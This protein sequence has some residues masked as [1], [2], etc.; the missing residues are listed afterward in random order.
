MDGSMDGSGAHNYSSCVDSDSGLS[1]AEEGTGSEDGGVLALPSTR[2]GG[3]FAKARRGAALPQHK[4]QQRLRELKGLFERALAAGGHADA[5][6]DKRFGGKQ[7]HP[8]GEES[9]LAAVPGLGV[10]LPVAPEPPALSLVPT[11]G[12]GGAA[13][14]YQHRAAHRANQLFG[15]YIFLVT[16]C[17]EIA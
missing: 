16:S 8:G 1:S 17:L 5:G 12:A 15:L 6:S 7:P 10:P 13:W 3:S 14:W 11:D 2:R 4:L 9:P